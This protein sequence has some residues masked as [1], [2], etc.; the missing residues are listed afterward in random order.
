M[1]IE[2]AETAGGAPEIGN[3]LEH[4]QIQTASWCNRECAFC[5]SGTFDIPKTFMTDDVLDRIARE[6]QRLGF[7]GRFSPYLMNEPLLDKHLPER[8]A[9]IRK[10][11]DKATFFIST[12]GD[13]LSLEVG[14]R[15]FAAGLD[16]MLVNLYDAEGAVRART[17]AAVDALIAAM[18][19]LVVLRDT[20][21][22]DLVD[23]PAGAGRKLIALTDASDWKVAELT[24]R[25]GNVVGA[26][27]PTEPLK[28]GCYR[29][30]RQ[31]YV[32]YTG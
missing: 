32:R 9:R 6:L 13:A 11:L 22:T 12:N 3:T 1:I 29:P 18:P 19:D 16:R 4:V 17:E 23:G 10:V 8:I 27:V 7:R 14:E 24:N 28:A 30:F 31:L 15:L 20:A 5:P 26:A 21:F 2:R 25:A